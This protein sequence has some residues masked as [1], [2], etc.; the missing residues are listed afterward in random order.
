MKSLLLIFLGGGTGLSLIHI[1]T[2]MKHVCIFLH[3][4]VGADIL[5][6]QVLEPKSEIVFS[7]FSAD[8]WA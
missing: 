4:L 5:F 8:A 6:Q 7:N 3:P 1:S 2:D